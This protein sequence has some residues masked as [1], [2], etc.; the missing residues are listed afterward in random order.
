MSNRRPF[1][2][3]CPLT[4]LLKS[5]LH[6]AKVQKNKTHR[7]KTWALGHL[8]VHYYSIIIYMIYPCNT[9]LSRAELIHFLDFKTFF[10]VNL[11]D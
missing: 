11:Q 4:P 8:Y 3:S 1:F 10:E 5:I 7:P 9:R 2:L 6:M